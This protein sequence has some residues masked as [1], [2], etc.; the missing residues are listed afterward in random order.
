MTNSGRLARA[1]ERLLARAQIASEEQGQFVADASHELK[2]P[3]M[4]IEGHARILSP[5]LGPNDVAQGRRRRRSSSARA[6]GS[7]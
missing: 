3:I 7:H 2:T 4:A 1:F 6:T 5:A